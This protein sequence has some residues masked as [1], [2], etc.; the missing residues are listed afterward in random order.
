MIWALLLSSIIL[1]ILTIEAR[2]GFEEDKLIASTSILINLVFVRMYISAP[3]LFFPKAQ[4]ITRSSLGV[5][6][7]IV[8]LIKS[9]ILGRLNTSIA[10]SVS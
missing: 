10:G 5:S 4:L 1:S 8:D 7:L 9:L 6:P 2:E 3:F